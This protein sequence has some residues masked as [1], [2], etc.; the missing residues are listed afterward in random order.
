MSLQ[1]E[2]KDMI[3]DLLAGGNEAKVS[4]EQVKKR[5]DN[6][7]TA[8][9]GSHIPSWL[10]DYPYVHDLI[11]EILQLYFSEGAMIL[12]LGGGTGRMSRLLLDR[13]PSCHMVVQDFSANMLKE[14][15]TTLRD[16][17]GSFECVEGDFFKETFDLGSCKFNFVV[18]VNA[19]H[20]GR[21][22]DNYRKLYQKIYTWLKPGGCFICLDHVAGVTHELAALNYMNWAEAL[23]SEMDPESIHQ[24]IETTIREDSP[25]SLEQHLEFLKGCGFNRTDVMW[26]KYIFGLYVGFKD[27]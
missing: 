1:K 5:F 7:D 20:H 15:P 18:S 24:I 9:Y 21:H 4:P 27:H 3:S 10:P 23:K 19:I 12:D 26:K 6:L 11:C 8:V 13:F 17:P 25:L 16:Y 2:L 22:P 14:V